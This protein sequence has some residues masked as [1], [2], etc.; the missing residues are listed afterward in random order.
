MRTAPIILAL[1]ALTGCVSVEPTSGA[2]MPL[3][4]SAGQTIGS[5]RAWEAHGSVSF[6]VRATGLPHG[7]HGIH[8]HD[9]G[10]CDPPDF[11]SAGS[12]WNPWGMQHGMNNLAGPHAGDL[13]NVWVSADGVLDAIVTLSATSMDKLMDRDGSAIVLHAQFDDYETDPDGRSGPRIACAIIRPA[14][15]QR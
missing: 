12:H 14:A 10:R 11:A 5:V 2:L 13:P 1:S 4:N 6:R 7:L 15:E 8:V 3:I 9:V